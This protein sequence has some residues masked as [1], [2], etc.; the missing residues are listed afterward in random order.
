MAAPDPLDP[1]TS[2]AE[3]RH[4]II[5]TMTDPKVLAAVDPSTAPKECRGRRGCKADL[6]IP[7]DTAD[8][9]AEPTLRARL[10][11][12]VVKWIHEGNYAVPKGGETPS[13][14]GCGSRLAGC[15]LTIVG[16]RSPGA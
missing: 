15:R 3:P 6:Y 10:F 1:S 7:G 11:V 14:Y 4:S 12:E 9:V 13:Y 16:V 5:K 8:S 2:N